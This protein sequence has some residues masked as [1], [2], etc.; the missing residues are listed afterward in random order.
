MNEKCTDET[1]QLFDFEVSF[2][3]CYILEF[4]R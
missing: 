1:M 3:L 2:C 4:V